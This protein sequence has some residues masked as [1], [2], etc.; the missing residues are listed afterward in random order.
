MSVPFLHNVDLNQNELQNAVIQLLA[1]DPGSP[2]DG[3]VWV[4]TTSHTLKVRLNGVTI[5]LGRLDQ[6]TAPTAA[7]SLG[8]QRITNLADPS[9][10]TDAV[11]LQ[12]VQQ[13]LGAKDWK[14]SVVAATTANITLS[15]EQT[16]DGV[17]VTAGDRVLVKNQSAGSENGIYVCASGAWTRA[18]DFDADNEVT[19]GA[20]VFVEEGTAGAGKTFQLTTTG[21][22][23]VGTTALTFTVI[24]SGSSLSKYADEIG[25][26]SDT[27]FVVTH[28]L[29]TQDAVVEVREVASPYNQ[30]FCDVEFTSVNTI[31][32]KFSVAPTSNQYRVTVVG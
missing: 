24:S 13:L 3:Q 16:I 31:T 15:G 5:A 32:C 7:V 2:V 9:A 12:Y 27:S 6:I 21:A 4:N 28:N 10:N 8:S 26:G 11:T 20:S 1:S 14:E 25:N 22:I 18:T 19:S 29:N 17:S 30:V 23:V